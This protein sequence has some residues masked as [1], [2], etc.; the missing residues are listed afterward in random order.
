M[1]EEIK[2]RNGQTATATTSLF[3]GRT[4]GALTVV[5]GDI[6][7]SL[8]ER[9]PPTATLVSSISVL[10]TESWLNRLNEAA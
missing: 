9:R 1:F 3:F 10:G 2:S 5:T 6:R 7:S 4:Y 8:V